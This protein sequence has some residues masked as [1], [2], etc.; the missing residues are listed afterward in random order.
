MDEKIQKIGRSSAYDLTGRTFGRL[1]A[2]WPSGI[3]GKHICWLALCR[4]GNT[5]IV[6]ATLL[7]K[8]K[9]RSC[10]CLARDIHRANCQ[11]HPPK[12]RHGYARMH[13]V[14]TTFRAWDAMR[15]RCLNPKD[16]N[17]A[18][19]GGR[20]I[21]ICKRWDKFENFL[22]DMGERPCGH[23][24]SGRCRYTL[25]RRDN[26]GNY[27]PKNCRWATAKQQANNR[28]PRS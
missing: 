24:P 12:L 23:H 2:Q 14:T 15:Q 10:G 13:R 16:K 21:R 5:K 8:R 27:T 4:C 22:A 25:D 1:T 28:R 20:G 26:D 17:Y 3:L 7:V 19:Y 18:S 6:R 11:N 9:V